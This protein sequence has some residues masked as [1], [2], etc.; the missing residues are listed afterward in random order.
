M[1]PQSSSKCSVSST[2]SQKDP[3]S[4]GRSQGPLFPP[5]PT[6]IIGRN[7]KFHEAQLAQPDYFTQKYKFP[8]FSSATQSIQKMKNGCWACEISEG[9]PKLLYPP[10]VNIGSE[11]F[12]APKIGKVQLMLHKCCWITLTSRYLLC[13][14]QFSTIFMKNQISWLLKCCGTLWL[15][16]AQHLTRQAEA[17]IHAPRGKRIKLGHLFSP[18]HITLICLFIPYSVFT[19]T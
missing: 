8:W 17:L 5:E 19:A 7:L 9:A 12:I 3:A 15:S 16:C 2:D 1:H 10:L 13:Q 14:S 18:S 11:G 6:K 4:I